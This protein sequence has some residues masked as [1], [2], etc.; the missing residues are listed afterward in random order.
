MKDFEKRLNENKAKIK[1]VGIAGMERFAERLMQS[2]EGNE[3]CQCDVQTTTI[4][5]QFEQII[6]TTRHN[7]YTDKKIEISA[8]S[9]VMSK[10]DG[11]SRF[12]I[13]SDLPIEQYWY[14]TDFLIAK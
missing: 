9:V 13:E 12:E 2:W 8:M 7:D 10:Q 14:L 6:V 5:K 1:K 4:N 3:F 11:H